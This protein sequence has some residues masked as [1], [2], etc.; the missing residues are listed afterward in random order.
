VFHGD[1]PEESCWGIVTCWEHDAADH[2]GC[3]SLCLGH[4]DCHPG[5]NFTGSYRP[6][7]PL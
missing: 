5:N 6:E 7:E 1:D 4:R 2:P 3:E